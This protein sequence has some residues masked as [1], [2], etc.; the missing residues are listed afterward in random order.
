MTDKS[1]A[2][3]ED[4]FVFVGKRGKSIKEI[5]EE[6]K[7]DNNVDVT[8]NSRYILKP[9]IIEEN[10][11]L[12]GESLS[13]SL[14]RWLD[15]YVGEGNVDNVLETLSEKTTYVLNT[16]KL[17]SYSGLNI[18]GDLGALLVPERA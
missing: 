13:E 4:E 1:I 18:I 8:D 9:T 12:N 7:D 6:N 16:I 2:D 15:S 14:K 5:K 10:K 3:D 11:K 17:Y